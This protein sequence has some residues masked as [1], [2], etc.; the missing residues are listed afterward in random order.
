[1][2]QFLEDKLKHTARNKGLTGRRAARY[3][4]GAMNNLGVVHGNQITAKG[5]DMEEKHERDQ[6]R[7]LGRMKKRSR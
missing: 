2:P 6:M 3:V 1:M 4:F 5:R 7:G